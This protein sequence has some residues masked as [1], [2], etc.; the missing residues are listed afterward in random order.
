MALAGSRAIDAAIERPGGPLAE[1]DRVIGRITARRPAM[2]GSF[3]ALPGGGEEGFLPDTAAGEAGARLSI[4][5]HISL[6]VTRGAQGGKGPRL[7]AEPAGMAAA[8]P[9]RRLARGPGAIERLAALHGAA[10]I[11]VETPSLAAGLPP[12]LRAR[13]R[14]GLG[15]EAALAAEIW[16]ALGESE[17]SLPGGARCTITPTPALTAIDVDAGAATG[18]RAGKTATQLAL[19]RR[20]LPA[21]ARQIRLR[22][23]AGAILL[24]L[25]GLPQRLRTALGEDL[26]MALAEDPL[27]PRF[28][29]FTALGLAEIERRRTAPPLHELLQ[30]AH[31]A[32]LAGLAAL[33]R[34]LADRPGETLTLALAPDLLGALQADAQ[35]LAEFEARVGRMP[36]L[37]SEPNLGAATAGWRLVT[38]M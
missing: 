9:L 11:R 22:N 13:A 14:I 24:D 34:A 16:A 36:Q 29:G 18:A 21:I 19:N 38:N 8:P 15:P 25:A 32:A 20:V 37:Q 30:D 17:V 6:R 12:G 4:G 7:A 33:A 27:Q 35:A 28:L 23:L 2:A 10:D 3:V 1:G 26:R 31:G 5:D